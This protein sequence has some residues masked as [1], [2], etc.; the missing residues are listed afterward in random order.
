[1]CIVVSCQELLFSISILNAITRLTAFLL[2]QRN[3]S[4]SFHSPSCIFRRQHVLPVNSILN[5]DRSTMIYWHLT[6][7]Y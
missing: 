5:K 3:K 2:N 4:D 7:E 6:P 1:M